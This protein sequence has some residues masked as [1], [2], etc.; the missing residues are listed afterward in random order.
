MPEGYSCKNCISWGKE[1][2]LGCA[3]CTNPD[4]PE[5][6]NYCKIH[7]AEFC[8][9]WSPNKPLNSEREKA[10]LYSEGSH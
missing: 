4:S 1:I 9:K 8:V 2:F 3:H 7:H 10:G 5:Y 6:S